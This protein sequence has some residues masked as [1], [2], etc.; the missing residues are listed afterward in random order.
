MQQFSLMHLSI[1][2]LYSHTSKLF[3]I[4][5]TKV[6]V[7]CML[8]DFPAREKKYDVLREN[9]VQLKA[10]TFITEDFRFLDMH[11][12]C[13]RRK[14][15]ILEKKAHCCYEDYIRVSVSKLCDLE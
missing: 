6:Y 10:L 8:V 12:P 2:V 13:E 14:D 9:I 3:C 4:Y 1:Q 5:F 11:F 15:C 7:S